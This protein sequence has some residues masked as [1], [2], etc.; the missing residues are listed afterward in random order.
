MRVTTPVRWEFSAEEAGAMMHL[1]RG[2]KQ[3]RGTLE[4]RT[5]IALCEKDR[6]TPEGSGRPA[7][8][9]GLAE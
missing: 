3:F 6:S 1:P 8:V 7:I 5:P 2:V 4:G 9:K